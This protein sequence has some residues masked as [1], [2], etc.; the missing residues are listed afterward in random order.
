MASWVH[1]LHYCDCYPSSGFVNR[2]VLTVNTV[3]HVLLWALAKSASWFGK[4]PS[5]QICNNN[6]NNNINNTRISIL[7]QGRNFRHQL[8]RYCPKQIT[9]QRSAVRYKSCLIPKVHFIMQ[10]PMQTFYFYSAVY[11]F[12]FVSKFFKQILIDM[13]LDLSSSDFVSKLSSVILKHC[14]QVFLR[15]HCLDHFRTRCDSTY[16]APYLTHN[17]LAYLTSMLTWRSALSKT[18]CWMAKW[19]V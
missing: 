18:R 6:S 15:L 3:G 9:E 14:F 17:D 8:Q 7:P 11:I 12:Y 10:F 16:R 4:G 19:F 1:P 13:D 5:A 2:H